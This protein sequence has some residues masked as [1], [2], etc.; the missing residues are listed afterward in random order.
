MG[1]RIV[2]VRVEGVRTLAKLDVPLRPLTVLIGENGAGKSTFVEILEI[3]RRLPDPNFMRDLTGAHGGMS[4]LL[5]D[6]ESR[7]TLGLDVEPGSPGDLLG[8]SISLLRTASGFPAIDRERLLLGQQ[9]C[10]ER[11]GPT[12]RILDQ[13]KGRLVDVPEVRPDQPL[14]GAYG[15]LPPQQAIGR[16]KRALEGITVYLPYSVYPSWSGWSGGRNQRSPLRESTTL[17]RVEKLDRYG[18]NLASAYQALRNDFGPEHW[19]QTL[20]YVRLGLGD[21]IEDVPVVVDPGGGRVAL[22][23]KFKELRQNVPA[24]GIP[25]GMLAYLAHVALYRLAGGESLIAFDEPDLHLHPRLIARVVGF[26]EEL[27]EERPVIL[28]T[29]SDRVLDCLAEPEKAVVLM[30]LDAERRA[31]LKWPDAPAL[32]RWIDRFAGFAE[33]RSGGQ[34]ASFFTAA[35]PGEA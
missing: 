22:A 2:R 11:E 35:G 9:V 32:R 5:R 28:T 25:D 4:A 21:S 1:D 17:V 31:E 20:E 3:L 23:L 7:I 15:N 26:F 18:E 12:V 14:I 16:M 13:A 27:S 34:E 10:I 24:V 30:E 33:L 19:R 29:H 8:Y 6:G